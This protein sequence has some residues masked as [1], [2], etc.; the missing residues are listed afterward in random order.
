MRVGIEQVMRRG[1]VAVTALIFLAGCAVYPEKIPAAHVSAEKYETYSCTQLGEELLKV[2]EKKIEVSGHQRRKASDDATAVGVALFIFSPA[3]YLL[4]GPD[5]SDELGRL[6]GE[7]EAALQTAVKKE[8]AIKVQLEVVRRQ[9][10]EDAEK[11]REE[12]MEADRKII[13]EN[14]NYLEEGY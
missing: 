5:Y 7:Y 6:K 11:R 3:L 2:N 10:E 9:W 4:K 12:V 14:R 1:M 8:C 13:R